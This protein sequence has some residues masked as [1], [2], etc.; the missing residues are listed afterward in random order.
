MN[1]EPSAQVV[2]R[3]IASPLALGFVGLAM[4]TTMLSALQLSW[5]PA[6]QQRI[7]AIALLGF[8][9]PLQGL[10]SVFGF[11]GRDTVVATG[12][13]GA[14]TTPFFRRTWITRACRGCRTRSA[15]SLRE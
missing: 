1:G 4:G 10:A 13:S 9:A 14:T 6:T 5:I 11:L 3:P 12:T 8:V 7:V 15:R 2:L